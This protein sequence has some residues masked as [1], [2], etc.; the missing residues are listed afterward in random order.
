MAGVVAAWELGPLVILQ[1]AW[2]LLAV[3]AA[4][5]PWLAHRFSAW[6]TRR[7]TL[8]T[9]RFASEAALRGGGRAS[10]PRDR[11]LMAMRM[12]M[13]LV[14]C[15]ALSQC[16]WRADPG[17]DDGIERWVW[18]DRSASMRARTGGET[19]FDRAKERAMAELAGLRP[20]VDRAAVVWVTGEAAVVEPGVT[21]DAAGLRAAIK[22]EAEA[23]FE[24]AAFDRAAGLTAALAARSGRGPLEVVW[25]DDG[26]ADD[27]AVADAVEVLR[28]SGRGGSLRRQV[29]AGM[30]RNTAITSMRLDPAVA[31]EGEAVTVHL[32]LRRWG[33]DAAADRTLS[34][35]AG[36]ALVATRRVPLEPGAPVAVTVS[37]PVERIGEL[38]DASGW[39]PVHA[40]VI[41]AGD[42]VAWDDRV[43]RWL[44]VTAGARLAVDASEVT[45][46]RGREARRWRERVALAWR[47]AG[48]GGEPVRRAM[49]TSSGSGVGGPVVWWTDDAMAAVRAAEGGASVV[50]VAGDASTA[51]VL[52]GAAPA[53]VAGSGWAGGRGTLRLGLEDHALVEALDGVRAMVSNVVIDGRV[54]LASPPGVRVLLR[55]DAGRAVA[56]SGRLGGGRLAILGFG[57]GAEEGG[58]SRSPMFVPLVHELTGSLADRPSP[59][60]RRV[61]GETFAAP[62][63]MRLDRVLPGG[64]R[65]PVKVLERGEAASLAGPGLW[66]AVSVDGAPRWTGEVVIPSSESAPPPARQ[67]ETARWAASNPPGEEA[68][69]QA[70]ATAVAEARPWTRL[71]IAM[72]LALAAGELV[73]L[74]RRSAGSGRRRGGRTP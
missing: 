60:A 53:R 38:A 37:L 59:A 23:G 56:T 48:G 72:A 57:W 5:L 69:D 29:V 3:A 26:Q 49:L 44:R 47:S 16:A 74:A 33:E 10:R 55:D 4:A 61:A 11:A 8:P 68:V 25:I 36:G 63:R 22:A 50:L 40:E 45:N 70:G 32:R 30:E 20:N 46:E 34:V 15:A 7:S 1:P 39:L 65:L 18:I 17:G 54:E 67:G 43:S 73:W 42:G 9:A 51:G 28:S 66:Q 13:L 14:L 52:A 12:L 27:A 62:R 41:D 58:V 19:A 6:L 24:P 2:L 64:G 21:G 35:S 31:A 71:L